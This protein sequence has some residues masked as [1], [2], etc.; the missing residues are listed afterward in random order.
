MWSC[1]MGEILLTFPTWLH[2]QM[3]VREHV[4]FALCFSVTER[5]LIQNNP[6]SFKEG[7]D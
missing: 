1:L 2:L 7:G 4:G 3:Q 6:F 5:A